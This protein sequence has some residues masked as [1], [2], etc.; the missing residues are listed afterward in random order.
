MSALELF[1]SN[2]L[3][4]R[5]TNTY[6]VEEIEH[7][8][9]LRSP[10]TLKWLLRR[11]PDSRG[12]RDLE[13]ALHAPFVHEAGLAF[14]IE[15]LKNSAMKKNP[16]AWVYLGDTHTNDTTK[17]LLCYQ[18]A[19]SLGTGEMTTVIAICFESLG[20]FAAALHEFENAAK[21]GIKGALFKIAQYWHYGVCEQWD[22]DKA[23]HYYQR[24][25]L[26]DKCSESM[27]VLGVLAYDYGCPDVGILWLTAATAKM[28]PR[29]TLTLAQKI[30][31]G[32]GCVANPQM[33]K[34][35]AGF[36]LANP[37]IMVEAA[38]FISQGE[39]SLPLQPPPS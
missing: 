1:K 9:Q 4:V 39:A 11:K 28:H 7:R 32:H 21:K 8:A 15:F 25:A 38:E 16:W 14:Q 13:I 12:W 30:K 37:D 20:Y 31:K 22:M 17:F 27:Y 23:L 6:T 35:V 18:K 3:K 10:E 5:K 34:M 36:A 24:A 2:F 33:A 29:A 26:E 19:S